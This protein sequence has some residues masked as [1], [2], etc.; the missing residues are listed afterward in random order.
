MH[1]NLPP[2][3]RDART[4]KDLVC[5]A[6]AGVFAMAGTYRRLPKSGAAARVAAGPLANADGARYRYEQL[7]EGLAHGRSTRSLADEPPGTQRQPREFRPP[8]GAEQALMASLGIQFDGQAYSFA[9]YRYDRLAD[10]VKFARQAQ[11]PT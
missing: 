2:S 1:S 5:H 7:S 8:T 6:A 10:A 4:P 9:G 3:N 11:G